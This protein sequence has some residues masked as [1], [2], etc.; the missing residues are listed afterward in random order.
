MRGRVY[1]VKNF[2][3]IQGQIEGNNFLLTHET[4]KNFCIIESDRLKQL[5]GFIYIPYPPA[6][7]IILKTLSLCYNQISVQ[8]LNGEF[9]KFDIVLK[10]RIGTR[11][12][13]KRATG[14]I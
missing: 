8:K 12:R 4:I 10:V 7:Y 9:I 6:S 14:G 13:N 5:D 2:G 3:T 11:T 1:K